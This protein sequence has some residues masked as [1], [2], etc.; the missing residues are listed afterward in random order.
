MTY[1]NIFSVPEQSTAKET[2]L[3]RSQQSASPTGGTWKKSAEEIASAARRSE[4]EVPAT[5]D[6]V[7]VDD[8]IS[9]PPP[10]KCM[11]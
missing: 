3:S 7:R 1:S 8:C 10:T 11:F 6:K 2:K 4:A 9:L 5:T